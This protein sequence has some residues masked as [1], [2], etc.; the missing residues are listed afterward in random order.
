MSLKI[1]SLMSWSTWNC[2]Y[3]QSPSTKLLIDAG[4]SWKK[5]EENLT[6]IGVH[7]SEITSIC[8]SHEHIDHI[9]SA[10]TL[11][12]KYGIPVLWNRQT[13]T[14]N[15]FICQTRLQNS[16]FHTYLEPD[17]TL[18]IWDIQLTAFKTSHDTT[19]S[20]FYTV[21]YQDKKIAC[22][23]DTG[24]IT[25]D[26]IKHLSHSHII[27]IESNHDIEM[28]KN[29]HRPFQNKKRILSDVWHLSNQVC[30]E[31]IPLISS[32]HTHSII[33]AHLSHDH[34]SPNLAFQT[35]SNH[36][37]THHPYLHSRLKIH[38]ADSKTPTPLLQA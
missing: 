25:P 28:V 10:W 24:C 21:K 6:K 20:Q 26:I 15:Y 22:I 37:K 1:A 12:R 4:W 34:N 18:E 14:S 9:K 8:I 23:T 13:L 32:V 35:I 27:L 38:I 2:T 29:W 19:F 7:L 5:I 11:S 31:T 30:A 17:E 33:L 36:L 16:P 3:I